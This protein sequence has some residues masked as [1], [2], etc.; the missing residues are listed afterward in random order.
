MAEEQRAPRGRDRGPREEK[1]DDGMMKKLVAVNRVSKTVKGGRQF[2]FTALTV[3]GDGNGR[4]GFGFGKAR[5]VPVAIQKAMAHARKNLVNVSLRKDTLH[6][7][8]RGI[9][10]AT[11]VLM[12]PAS[13]GTGVI[14]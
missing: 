10:G 3:V 8:V 9:H 12:Q 5:E 14:A 7:S 6:Y 11:R 2:T 4:V 13:S 1:I